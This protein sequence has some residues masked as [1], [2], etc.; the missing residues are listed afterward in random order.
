MNVIKFVTKKD[1]ADALF[2][3][4][5]SSPQ[6]PRSG[7]YRTGVRAGIYSAMKIE[8]PL[9]PYQP[10]TAESD[11]WLSGLECGRNIVRCR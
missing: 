4:A 8:K 3:A 7:A 6:E 1:N 10:G 11:A 5:F 9:N 2:D